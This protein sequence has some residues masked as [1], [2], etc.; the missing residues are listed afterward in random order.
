M[1]PSVPDYLNP[2]QWHQ[3]VAVS[4]Q[5]CARIFR[6][7]GAPQDALKAFGLNAGDVATWERAVDLIATE[8]CA[9]PMQR[10]A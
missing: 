1:T 6:D 8:I 3:A 9:H 7:G 10:A 4:R 2:I 5:E